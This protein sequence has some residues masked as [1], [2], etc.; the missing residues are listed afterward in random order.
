MHTLHPT[1][2]EPSHLRS[3]ACTCRFCQDGGLLSVCCP[4]HLHKGRHQAAGCELRLQQVA[5][6]DGLAAADA[7]VVRAQPR[8]QHPARASRTFKGWARHAQPKATV[9]L[10]PWQWEH[11]HF[12]STLRKHTCIQ[13]VST[14]QTAKHISATDALV[15]PIQPRQQHPARSSTAF[16]G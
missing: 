11:S 4:T 8:Q 12:S 13:G 5:V 14:T 6:D 9:S 7:L 3:K 16:K 1:G 10:M 2:P 15:V